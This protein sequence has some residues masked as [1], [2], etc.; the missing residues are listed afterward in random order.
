VRHLPARVSS[1]H[2]Y[3]TVSYALYKTEDGNRNVVVHYCSTYYTAVRVGG[4]G[5]GEET[6]AMRDD[7]PRT[8]RE[9]VVYWY[10]IQ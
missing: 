6:S 7:E 10:S 1:T 2:F 5:E 4:P 3:E 8:E 9:C